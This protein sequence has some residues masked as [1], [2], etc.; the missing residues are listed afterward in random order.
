[1]LEP[2][3]SQALALVQ[4]GAL[5]FS[6]HMHM[7]ET[8]VSVLENVESVAQRK[9]LYLQ[10]LG[11][12]LTKLECRTDNPF[13]QPFMS[14][15]ALVDSWDGDVRE[16]NLVHTIGAFTTSRCRSGSSGCRL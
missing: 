4:S 1:M 9:A 6:Q 5:G 7:L 8:L 15:E 11:S 12:W 16:K 13:M 10:I 3:C 2:L 14:A